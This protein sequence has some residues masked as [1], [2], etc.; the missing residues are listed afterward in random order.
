MIRNVFLMLLKYCWLCVNK[1]INEFVILCEKQQE[2][3][4]MRSTVPSLSRPFFT[5]LAGW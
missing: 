1:Y 5:K 3:F 2:Y 4:F